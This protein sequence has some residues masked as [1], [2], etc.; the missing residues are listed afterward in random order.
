[1]QEENKENRMYLVSK[2]VVLGERTMEFVVCHYAGKF[3][4][5]FLFSW[6]VRESNVYNCELA[7]QGLLITSTAIPFT[8]LRC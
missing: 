8:C 4:N 7:S 1:M 2:K 3:G 6:E 5:D